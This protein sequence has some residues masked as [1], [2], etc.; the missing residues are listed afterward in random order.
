[1][2]S[3]R[4]GFHD[5]PALL[6]GLPRRR[7]D[8]LDPRPG[9]AADMSEQSV[10]SRLLITPISLKEANV[11]IEQHH[12]H[13]N[14]LGIG[15]LFAIAVSD[16]AVRGV[17]IVG[18]PAARHMWDGFTLEVRRVCT[19]GAENACS[20][21]Y[22]ACWRAVKAMGYRRLITYT[23][24]SEGGASLRAAGWKVLYQTNGDTWSGRARPRV[25]RHP[26]LPKWCWEAA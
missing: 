23:L 1:M 13:H 24:P 22:A 5:R 26:T 4:R 10:S 12:R 18:R 3:R 7:L 19:D 15:A 21:L 20:M 2:R 25:D 14:P 16:D 11:F 9:V 8:V 6:V 17:A